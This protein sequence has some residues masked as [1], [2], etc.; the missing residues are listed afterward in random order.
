MTSTLTSSAHPQDLSLPSDDAPPVPAPDDGAPKPRQFT[1]I[2]RPLTDHPEC[3]ERQG[4][5]RGQFES[6]EFIR[7]IPSVCAPPVQPCP[8]RR[9]EELRRVQSVPSVTTLLEDEEGE[10]ERRGR[11]R[12]RTI[13][14]ADTESVPAGQR[15][16]PGL[17]HPRD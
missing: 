3:A 11:R 16:Q 9:S 7:E 12:G 2:S 4:Y 14:F 10:E 8:V 6:V 13:T 17:E 15:Q 5:V 1:M